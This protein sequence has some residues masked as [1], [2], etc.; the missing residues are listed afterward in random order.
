M[1]DDCEDDDDDVEDEARLGDMVIPTKHLTLSHPLY[2]TPP[3]YVL[4]QPPTP[5]TDDKA[6]KKQTNICL[7]VYV[8]VH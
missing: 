4:N 3:A 2:A 1:D 5:P 6:N 7:A 8:A